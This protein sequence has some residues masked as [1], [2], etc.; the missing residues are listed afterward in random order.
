M[1]QFNPKLGVGGDPSY[2]GYSK[3]RQGDSSAAVALKG[4]A[5]IFDQGI[6]FVDEAIEDRAKSATQEGIQEVQ[7]SL[8]GDPAAAPTG[9]ADDLVIAPGDEGDSGDDETSVFGG[10]TLSANTDITQGGDQAKRLTQAYKAGKITPT[11]YWGRMNALAKQLKAQYPGYGEQID[12][13][14]QGT[15]GQLPAN[16][17]AQA[18]R[19]QYTSIVAG[20]NQEEKKFQTFV[21]QAS[22]K[23]YLPVDYYKRIEQGQPYSQLEVYE[24]VRAKAAENFTLEREKDRLAIANSVGNLTEEDAIGVAQNDLNATVSGILNDAV[25]KAAV[26][27][28]YAAVQKGTAV[29]PQEKDAL[30]NSFGQLRAKALQAIEARMRAP[31]AN[32]QTYYSLLKDPTKA[33]QIKEQAMAEFDILEGLLKDDQFGLFAA[34]MN[35]IKSQKESASLKVLEQPTFRYVEAIR[36]NGGGDLLAEMTLKA[37]QWARLADRDQKALVESLAMETAA[38]TPKPMTQQLTTTNRNPKASPA[39]K[40]V[41]GRLVIENNLKA[42]NAKSTTQTAQETAAENMFGDGNANFLSHFPYN[43]RVE[44]YG[45]LVNPT[46]TKSMAEIKA[47]KPELWAKYKNWAESSFIALQKANIANVQEGVSEAKNVKVEY[48]PAVNQFFVFPTEEGKRAAAARL[49]NQDSLLSGVDRWVSVEIENAV[50]DLNRGIKNL[51]G[52]LKEDGG[53]PAERIMHLLSVAGLDTKRP[54]ESSFFAKAREAIDK[55]LNPPKEGTQN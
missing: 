38:G 18:Q 54:H 33:K 11:M 37:P 36:Q 35:A 4:A 49:K 5:S 30:R 8:L 27:A 29:T 39:D 12:R 53:K 9:T 26:D 40:K 19:T 45:A 34:Q 31:T 17:Y 28:I 23:G 6:K 24:H 32:G 22:M 1:V 7:T 44:V 15:V 20:Q 48:D 3:E 13:T 21:N 47:R 50:V 55:A 41:A 52:I 42:L 46:V 43:Q 10:E 51:E 14:F 16:A 25:P 2:I